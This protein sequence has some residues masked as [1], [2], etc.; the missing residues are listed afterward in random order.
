MASVPGRWRP[1]R[2]SQRAAEILEIQFPHSTIIL[3]DALF[4]H[5]AKS[6]CGTRPYSAMVRGEEELECNGC[7]GNAAPSH[8]SRVPTP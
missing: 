5:F 8:F 1:A 2:P 3:Q 7:V 6:H 4:S